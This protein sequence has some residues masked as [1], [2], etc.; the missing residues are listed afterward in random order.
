MTQSAFS[1]FDS[2]RS[3]TTRRP[4]RAV[5]LPDDVELA[6]LL[7]LADQDRLGDVVVRKHLRHAAREVR[8]LHADDGVDDLVGIVVPA[9]STALTHMLN[10]ITCA[11]M[12]SF[13]TRLSFFVNAPTS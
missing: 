6:V 13:V 5:G 3:P 9:F 8:D 7:D 12:G 11:S 4:A 1:G 10:P 2:S